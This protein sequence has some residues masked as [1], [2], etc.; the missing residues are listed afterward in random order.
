M[1]SATPT[2]SHAFLIV[3]LL[4]FPHLVMIPQTQPHHHHRF[5]D[6]ETMHAV[7][8]LYEFTLHQNPWLCDCRLRTF[9]Q[10]MVARRISLNFSPS[11][12]APERLDGQIW[13]HLEINEF[14]CPP[15]IESIDTDVVVYEGWFA[16]ISFFRS[17]LLSFFLSPFASSFSFLLFVYIFP[18]YY[19]FSFLLLSL[20]QCPS[21]PIEIISNIVVDGHA[22]YITLRVNN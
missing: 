6:G 9:R 16:L 4:F 22:S 11:C 14:A 3:F 13:N 21:F 15:T 8:Q 20:L 7:P 5:I 12:S 18:P 17:C 19:L 10:W 1:I 2:H